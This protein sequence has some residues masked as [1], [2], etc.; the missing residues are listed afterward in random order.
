M[1]E[2]KARTIPASSSDCCRYNS[3]LPLWMPRIAATELSRLAST[4]P[5]SPSSTWFNAASQP[6][7]FSPSG[8]GDRRSSGGLR[9]QGQSGW[10]V[11]GRLTTNG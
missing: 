9:G 11:I 5:N 7:R 2:V 1:A 8:Q 10:A 4:V 6:K 3:M